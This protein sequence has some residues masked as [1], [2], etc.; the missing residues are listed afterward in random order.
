MFFQ[1]DIETMPRT[2]IEAIQLERLKKI[3]K[4]CYDNIGFYNKK[5]TEAGVFD[6]SKIKALSDIQYIPFTT[7]DDIRDNYP[8][9][10]LAVPMKDIVRI[11]ASSGT[12]GKPTVGVY[13]KADLD[14]W[15][16]CVARVAVAGGATADD[17]IQ[18]SFG[19]G[20]FT[21]AL[22][23]H[24]GLE[25]IGA[26]VI[27]ASSG[28]TAKQLMMFRD[29]G[30]TGLVATPS[31][32]LY[33]SEAMKEAGYPMSDYK[34]RLGI[35]GSEPCTEEMRA[36]IEQNMRVRVSDNY[37]LTEI[38]GPGVSGDC[39]MRNGMH[40]AEDHFLPEIIDAKTGQRLG[41][42]EVGEL[43]VTTLTRQGMPVLRYRTKDITK[44]TYEKCECGRTHAR[45]AK[46]MGRTDDMLIIKGVNVFPTQ[47]ES[48][49]VSM[50]HVSPHYQLIVRRA[51]F[52]DNLE[53]KVELENGDLL[54]N[55]ADLQA[56]QK[57][58]HDKLKSVLGLETKVTLA[59]PKSLERFQGKAK[60]I[61]DLRNE[62]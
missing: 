10:M 23:L 59:E 58:I 15:S 41:E 33:L 16:D 40:F 53:V 36:Q 4:Y 6:G 39:E 35:L 37:G 54:E 45:M 51:N 18:I 1:K 49:L 11:H 2:D 44:I 19:Y 47:I 21:G 12:T 55:F 27:P 50:Q 56:L 29:F 38:G 5:L 26:T 28:N 13:T 31:Y 57:S 34:L 42:N 32:A 17:I 25:K 52:K 60:R 62:G 61:L 22:G 43:V 14:M 8:F 48:V 9:N 24:Y 7:K 20:L 30:V 46:T 3:V